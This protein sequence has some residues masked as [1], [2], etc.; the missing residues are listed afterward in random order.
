MKII[1][2]IKIKNTLNF[3]QN[4]QPF[5]INNREQIIEGDAITSLLEKFHGLVISK[6]Y[7]S[8]FEEVV[9]F[10]VMKTIDIDEND[11]VFFSFG[12]D[13]QYRG[14]LFPAF[15]NPTTGELEYALK[16]KSV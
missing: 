16:G 1:N 5:E 4:Y 11:Q 10:P 6:N 7:T 2:L 13:W 15:Q 12:M 9:T 3:Q 8:G 14:Y